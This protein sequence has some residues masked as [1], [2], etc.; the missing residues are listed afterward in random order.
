MTTPAAGPTAPPPGAMPTT[1]APNAA[2][3]AAAPM[4]TPQSPQGDIAKSRVAVSAAVKILQRVVAQANDPAVKTPLVQVIA[5]L[6]K[7]FGP[8]DPKLSDSEVMGLLAR[9]K[10]PGESGNTPTPP[11]QGAQ[12]QAHPKRAAAPQGAQ[13]A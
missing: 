10:G 6:T 5:A 2:G 3:P 9:A 13:A 4:M 11:P 8:F 1:P 12:P 7:S